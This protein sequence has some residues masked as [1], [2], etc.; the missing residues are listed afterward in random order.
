LQQSQNWLKGLLSTV[1]NENR[2]VYTKVGAGESIQSTF[3]LCNV[4]ITSEENFPIKLAKE[5]FLNN[6]VL[7][8]YAL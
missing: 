8:N 2:K 7:A 3:L 1:P 6:T 4:L 5:F